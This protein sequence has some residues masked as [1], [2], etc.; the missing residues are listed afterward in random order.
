MSTNLVNVI[1]MERNRLE[2][3]VNEGGSPNEVIDPLLIDTEM[4]GGED[5]PNLEIG[6]NITTV[7]A[8]NLGNPS[9]DNDTVM[10]GP[11]PDKFTEELASQISSQSKKTQI[12]LT[13]KFE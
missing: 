12:Y 8:L 3:R 10:A 2:E 1:D 13:K 11:V 5:C 7:I 9:V 6:S 4:V